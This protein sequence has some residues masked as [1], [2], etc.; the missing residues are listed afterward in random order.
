MVQPALLAAVASTHGAA[1]PGIT[2]CAASGLW[3]IRHL[4]LDV[5][6]APAPA[7]CAAVAAAAAAVAPAAAAAAAAAA[8]WVCVQRAETKH[9]EYLLGF[10]V[11]DLGNQLY[12][13]H[14]S[15]YG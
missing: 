2:L 14:V 9:L 10:Q 8:V 7:E 11:L 5:K 3:C 15:Y 1:L 12:A 13:E 6:L 4:H